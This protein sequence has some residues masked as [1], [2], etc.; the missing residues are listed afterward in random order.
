M[1]YG[2]RNSLYEIIKRHRKDDD[3]N[4]ALY[5]NVMLET[6]W[7]DQFDGYFIEKKDFFN[8]ISVQGFKKLIK[9][10]RNTPWI[11]GYDCVLEMKEIL[12]KC[13]GTDLEDL[14]ERTADYVSDL[15]E[16]SELI[17][18]NRSFSSCRVVLDK[19]NKAFFRVLYKDWESGRWDGVENELARI[20]LSS[21]EPYTLLITPRHWAENNGVLIDQVDGFKKLGEDVQKSKIKELLEVGISDDHMVIAGT[22]VD[23]TYKQEMMAFMLTYLNI[24]GMK[25][26]YAAYTYERNSRIILQMREDF[27]EEKH[28]NIS[29]HY[30]GIE[31][32]K[33]SNIVCGLSKTALLAFGWHIEVGVNGM[34]LFDERGEQIGWF[35]HYCGSRSDMG[36][37]YQR[38]QPYMQRWIVQKEKLDKSMRE[39]GIPHSVERVV[40]FCIQDYE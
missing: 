17:K 40:D 10:K 30:N 24:P 11:N 14:E 5:A 33:H 8:E 38:N 19:V 25:P 20:V 7:P 12:E 31:S 9:T 13:F 27:F 1:D 28:F 6:L 21:S 22:I 34:K 36:N 26:E 35:E 23:Y 37:R 32:F 29:I 15:S 16:L 39:A 4:V 2:S 18:L 3:F